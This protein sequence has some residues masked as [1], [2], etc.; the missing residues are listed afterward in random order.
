MT[1]DNLPTYLD[2]SHVQTAFIPFLHRKE[3][4]LENISQTEPSLLIEPQLF[5]QT[6]MQLQLHSPKSHKE[7][8]ISRRFIRNN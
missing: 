3:R 2:H 6:L 5:S 8:E 7:E 1:G 4:K